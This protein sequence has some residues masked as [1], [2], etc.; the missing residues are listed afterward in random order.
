ML[1]LCASNVAVLLIVVLVPVMNGGADCNANDESFGEI[2]ASRMEH[3][4]RP[5]RGSP[6]QPLRF[7]GEMWSY[8]SHKHTA[9]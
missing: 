8:M 7:C 5:W 9:D 4:C 6:N 3:V 2:D 1:T